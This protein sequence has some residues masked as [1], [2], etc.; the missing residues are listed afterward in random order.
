MPFRCH[1]VLLITKKIC[2]IREQGT[3]IQM[4]LIKDQQD[5]VQDEESIN[6]SEKN[7]KE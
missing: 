7:D 3:Q 2:Q 6:S 4:V 5:D 1:S